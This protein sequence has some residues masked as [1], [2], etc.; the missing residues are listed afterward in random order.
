[1]AAWDCGGVELEREDGMAVVSRRGFLRSAAA[2]PLVVKG[3][4][5]QGTE[6]GALLLVGTQ[7]SATSKGIYAYRF[8]PATGELTQIGLAAATDFPTFLVHS[9]DK[10][11]I[12]SVNELETYQGKPGGAVTSF[13]VE[14]G[15]LK[16]AEVNQV[17]SL[18]GAPCHI[19][20]DSTGRCVFVANYFGGSAASFLV[21]E[22]GRLSEAVSFFQYSGTGPD[23]GR[24]EG[25]HAH[26]VTLSPDERFL[27]VNDLGLDVIHVYTLDT[28]TAKLTLHD[29]PAWKAPT[30]GSGPRALR[31]HP[32]GKWAYCVT[33]MKSTVCVLRWD[34][35]KGVLE[36]VQE[37]SLLPAGH[38]GETG[39]ADIVLDHAGRFAYA[40]NRLDDF[41][42][43]FTVSDADGKL[44]LVERSSCGGKVPRHLALDK[45]ER[46]L[47]VA[48][49]ETDNISV[50]A[51]DEKTGRLGKTGKNFPISRPQCFVWM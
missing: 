32:N 27:M 37:I 26:R 38:T 45:T 8:D 16:L 48:N 5:A 11:M 39:A 33:E 18:G 14:Q 49:Q 50:F 24:Q 15:G 12:Y 41:L 17:P 21:G 10:K 40:A 47:L 2:L 43:T 22:G 6:S 51:R 19:A 13:V 9:Q 30:P 44:T 42:V 36:T 20:V 4:M 28:K 1:M 7:T 3:L 35:A 23:K 46:W 25:P 29:P 31:F 34:A